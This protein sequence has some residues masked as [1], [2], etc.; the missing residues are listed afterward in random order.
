M[1]KF[2]KLLLFGVLPIVILLIV[3]VF[4]LNLGSIGAFFSG[5]FFIA[6]A[7]NEHAGLNLWLAR[8]IAAPLV[9][10]AYFF[11]IRFI[12]AGGAKKVL[13]YASLVGVWS[14]VCIAMFFMQGSFSRKSGEALQYY[15]Q[16]D[17]GQIV[18]RDHSGV[19][20]DTGKSLQPVTPD[21]MRTYRLQQ[22]G[23]LKVDD[24]TLFDPQ[25]GQAL[26]RY[27]KGPDGKIELFPLEV[28]FHPQTGD[29]LEI[30]TRD[31][32]AQIR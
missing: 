5:V 18:L 16:D 6:T 7:M 15:F 27:Y 29:K 1:D 20:A 9:F 30:I 12:L 22:K 21:I 3:S 31:I 24:K 2:L 11:G 26:K 28:K 23:G 8:A 13:G 14:L 10:A 17:R 25:T 19:D 32:A 4:I